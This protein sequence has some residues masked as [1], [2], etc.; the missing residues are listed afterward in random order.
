MIVADLVEATP[1]VT[2]DLPLD[3]VLRR[4]GVRD[5]PA[6]PV[7]SDAGGRLLGLITREHITRV[8]ERSLLL[9]SGATT[10]ERR[11]FDPGL[12]EG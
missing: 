11:L 1:A 7:V 12:S 9:D 2:L 6:L 4:L 3:Q 8:V 10:A 5:L